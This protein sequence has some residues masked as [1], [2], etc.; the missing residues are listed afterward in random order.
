M[1]KCKRCG[2]IISS[3]I[4]SDFCRNCYGYEYNKKRRQKL[5][6]KHLC[7]SCGKRVKVERCCNCNE[8]IK[9]FFRCEECMKKMKNKK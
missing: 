6:K 7:P 9:Y 4:S 1:K 5:I 3:R 2:K 8:I